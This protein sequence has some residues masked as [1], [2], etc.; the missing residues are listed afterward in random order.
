MKTHRLSLVMDSLGLLRQLRASVAN[1]SN[2]SL[3]VSLDEVIVRLE[4]YVSS[5]VD[6]PGR[7][8]DALKVLAQGLASIP[9]I[10]RIIEMVRDQ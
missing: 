10:Q 9:G 8:G 6:D 7:I 3:M 2:H 1:D 5:G 4:L